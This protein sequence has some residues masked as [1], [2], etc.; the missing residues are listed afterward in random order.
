MLKFL[1]LNAPTTLSVKLGEF[2]RYSCVKSLALLL[3]GASQTQVRVGIGVGLG[4]IRGLGL[5]IGLGLGL[6]LSLGL[7]LSWNWSLGFR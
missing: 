4:R 7:S 2:D 1:M 6:G 3:G 5:G